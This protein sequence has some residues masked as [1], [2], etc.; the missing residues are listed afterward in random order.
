M[1]I[2]DSYILKATINGKRWVYQ[3]DT[4]DVWTTLEEFWHD[5]Y[6]ETLSHMDEAGQFPIE[7]HAMDNGKVIKTYQFI[8]NCVI[9]HAFYDHGYITLNEFKYQIT[10][11]NLRSVWLRLGVTVTGTEEQMEKLFNGDKATLR[12]LIE[13]KQ[14][15]LDSN[16]YIPE[17][18]AEAYNDTYGTDYAGYIEFEL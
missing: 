17:E 7:V 1:I 3:Y 10:K 11:D 12:N 13:R 2:T 9:F 5:D 15:I 14:F 16:S 6:P 4:N 8:F 18:E